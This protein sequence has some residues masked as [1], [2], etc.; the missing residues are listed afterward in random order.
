VPKEFKEQQVRLR[1]EGVDSSFHV[2]VNGQ[3]VGYSQGS[4]NPSE[5]DVTEFLRWDGEGVNRL[6]VTV[7]QWCDGSYLEDQVSG[8]RIF[9]MCDV[10]LRNP[11]EPQSIRVIVPT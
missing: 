1:F 7:Y 4:R 10:K 9:F 3:L 8:L 2:R 11:R 6:V 5:W